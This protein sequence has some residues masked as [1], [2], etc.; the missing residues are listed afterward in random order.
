MRS[1]MLLRPYCAIF[2]CF[3]LARA[4]F[5]GESE[6]VELIHNGL[7]CLSAA[8]VLAEPGFDEVWVRNTACPG[9]GS[10]PDSECA[11]PWGEPTEVCLEEAGEVDSLTA[12][13]S[14]LLDISGGRVRLAKT[15]DRAV[16]RIS[17]GEVSGRLDA[18]QESHLEITG[19]QLGSVGLSRESSLE[20]TGGE[21]RSLSCYDASTA[22]LGGSQVLSTLR[23]TGSSSVVITDGE[24]RDNFSVRCAALVTLQG[25]RITSDL[26]V[27]DDR[28]SSVGCDDG[29]GGGGGVIINSLSQTS[30][31]PTL[32]IHG[33]S[34]QVD[35]ATVPFGPLVAAAGRLTGVLSSADWLEAGFKR[36]GPDGNGQIV[37]VEAP[38][39]SVLFDDCEEHVI[40]DA[41]Y[42]TEVLELACSSALELTQHA[43]TRAVYA[44]DNSSALLREAYVYDTLAVRD[45][46]S[47]TLLAGSRV[48]ALAAFGDSSAEIDGGFVLGTFEL[49]IRST[50]LLL[51]GMAQ[52][53][54]LM[55]AAHLVVA[56]GLV[57]EAIQASN[58][59]TISIEDGRVEGSV[60]CWDDCSVELSGGQISH[61]SLGTQ[62]SL[63]FLPSPSPPDEP[64]GHITGGFVES[65]SVGSAASLTMTGGFTESLSTF[66]SGTARL[67]GG[68]VSQRLIAYDASLIVVEGS[69]FAV[70]GSAVTAGDLVAHFGL[71]T[72]TL[73]DGST[74]DV[75]F[76]QQYSEDEEFEDPHYI[77]LSKPTGTIRL[78]IVPEPAAGAAV[79]TTLATLTLLARR[80]R[81]C[82]RTN[83]SS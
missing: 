12:A 82:G 39:D 45:D 32:Q 1:I 72:G 46:A 61:L 25:G 55:D 27:A 40:D 66:L 78:E 19:G 70:D 38:F 69:G 52:R 76:H 75:E 48:E 83:Q 81:W 5:A 51:D 77:N 68:V 57:V 31:A 8:N 62:F 15:Q 47:A 58:A 3:S 18:V 64:S 4:G 2:L 9:E 42:S 17:G 23:A 35:G 43:V 65:I 11:E 49:G 29:P 56:G 14:S 60:Q 21:I 53:I 71:L 50:G 41:S 79:A 28:S 6:P 34:F 13:E 59:A 73:A 22:D 20:F 54:H 63:I 74:L 7:D 26:D 44:G 30:A 37:L 10:D 16:A 36:F 24:I 80:R 67:G 33:D